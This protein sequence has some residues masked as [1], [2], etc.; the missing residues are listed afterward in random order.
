MVSLL[1]NFLREGH[2]RRNVENPASLALV[3]PRIPLGCVSEY[4]EWDIKFNSKQNNAFTSKQN[5]AF[6]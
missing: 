1:L 2:R 5:N 6:T 3:A 4:D